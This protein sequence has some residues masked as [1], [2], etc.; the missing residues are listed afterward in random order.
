M[1]HCPLYVPPYPTLDQLRHLGKLI[2]DPYALGFRL[3]D[4]DQT[5]PNY[6]CRHSTIHAVSLYPSLGLVQFTNPN[7]LALPVIIPAA[8]RVDFEKMMAGAYARR[9]GHLRGHG[10]FA[11]R[12]KIISE[13]VFGTYAP[14]TRTMVEGEFASFVTYYLTPSLE[15]TRFLQD[16]PSPMATSSDE[17]PSGPECPEHWQALFEEREAVRAWLADE[18]PT[19][20]AGD[21][22]TFPDA[23]AEPPPAPNVSLSCD[24]A[25][26]AAMEANAPWN[27]SA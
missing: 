3:A 17:P 26:L 4:P 12:L 20:P 23:P 9:I 5:G 19:P 18:K 1:K 10:R 15:G 2:H 7:G 25:M 14:G 21:L 16:G 6:A 22:F 11:L 27:H 8:S 24:R 13:G